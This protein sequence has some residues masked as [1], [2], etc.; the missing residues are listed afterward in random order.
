MGPAKNPRAAYRDPITVDD[1]LASRLIAYPF[2][3][4]DAPGAG[5]D[6]GGALV[7]TSGD[8][9]RL[10]KPAVHVL[11]TGESGPRRR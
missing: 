10:P 4:L 8:R 1:V 11:G 5:P 9:A 2:H 3:L 7:I 6:G